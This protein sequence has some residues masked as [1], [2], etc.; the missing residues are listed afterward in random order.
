M[1]MVAAID[2]RIACA[3]RC[4][5]S[6]SANQ[7]MSLACL[8]LETAARTAEQ[9]D[10]PLA[11]IDI[12]L[13]QARVSIRQSKNV[14]ALLEQ[15]ARLIEETGYELR[16]PEQY[17]LEAEVELGRDRRRSAEKANAALT[18]ATKNGLT[19]LARRARNIRKTASCCKE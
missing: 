4:T 19:R 14:D 16:L 11:K 15:S 18:L 6:E 13:L 7:H 17:C 12:M 9:L 2:L 10:M 3:D 5:R 8:G 1:P